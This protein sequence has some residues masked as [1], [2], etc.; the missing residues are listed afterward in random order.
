MPSLDELDALKLSPGAP[1]LRHW[2]T[3]YSVNRPIRV[4]LTLFAADRNRLVY[5]GGD[6]SAGK[7]LPGASAASGN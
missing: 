2:R 5:E 3:A 6:A 1:V 7:V 4:T